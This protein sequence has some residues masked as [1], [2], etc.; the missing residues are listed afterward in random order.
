MSQSALWP[1]ACHSPEFHAVDLFYSH[2]STVGSVVL[3][4]LSGVTAEHSRVN[5]KGEGVLGSYPPSDHLGGGKE[6]N[7]CLNLVS[8]FWLF[9]EFSALLYL[10]TDSLFSNRHLSSH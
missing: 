2:G 1:L 10:I 6:R 4:G 8:A 9:P 3:G 7:I 5:P